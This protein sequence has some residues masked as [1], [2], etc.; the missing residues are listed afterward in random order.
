MRAAAPQPLA[1]TLQGS[2]KT[3]AIERLQEVIRRVCLESPDCELI[4]GG[5]KNDRGQPGAIE[6]FDNAE[7]IQFG[8]LHVQK[9]QVGRLLSA[10]EPA[11]QSRARL[12]A[13]AARRPD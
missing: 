9:D 2:L 6:R 7:A 12:V 13:P 4:V 10:H 5:D 8:H 1:N 11:L 3:F